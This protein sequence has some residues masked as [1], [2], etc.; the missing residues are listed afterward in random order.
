MLTHTQAQEVLL[1][2]T[3]IHTS[4]MEGHLKFW[5][6]GVSESQ[7][8]KKKSM[9]RTGISREVGV[10]S[11]L[12]IT[13]HGKK[14]EANSIAMDAWKQGLCISDSAR[15]LP[16]WPGFDSR[17][18][19]HIIFMRVFTKGTLV[20]SSHRKNLHFQILITSGIWGPQV[21]QSQDC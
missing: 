11:K 2:V 18:R 12:K 6:C 1:N 4:P 7:S 9:K 17:T 3:D 5:G 15:F 14:K 19:G 20:F 16:L 13:F 10:V 8:F 21:C